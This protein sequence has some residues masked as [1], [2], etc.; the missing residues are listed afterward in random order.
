MYTFVLLHVRAA[1]EWMAFIGTQ[2]LWVTGK[3]AIQA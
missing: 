3:F 1:M 2:Y